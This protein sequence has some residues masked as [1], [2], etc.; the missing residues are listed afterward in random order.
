M[1]IERENNEIIFRFPTNTN[2]DLVQDV[3]DY[4]EYCEISSKSTVRQYDVD[5]IV[6]KIKKGRWKHSKSKITK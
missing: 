4:F 3:S 1:K 6:K 5:K 2:I